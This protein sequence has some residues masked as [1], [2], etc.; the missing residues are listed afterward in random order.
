MNHPP[1]EN[2]NHRYASD[3][4][5]PVTNSTIWSKA[6]APSSSN[7]NLSVKSLSLA[8]METPYAEP[9]GISNPMSYDEIIELLNAS[10]NYVVPVGKMKGLYFQPPQYLREKYVS[11]RKQSSSFIQKQGYLPLPSEE[12]IHTA[13]PQEN[14]YAP[15]AR[16]AF[17]LFKRQLN[18]PQLVVTRGYEPSST[19]ALSSHSIG[20]AMDIYA[21]TPYDAIRMADTAWALGIRSIAIGPKFVHI[22]TGPEASWGY[23]NLAVYRGPGSIKQ[24]GIESGYR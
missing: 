7:T 4:Q 19:E 18:V 6:P 17:L 23:G 14:F 21:P 8:T 2:G 15:E 11:N 12:Y 1:K 9:T 3:D 16:E 13:G 5:W 22:D 10:A 20:I 24:G